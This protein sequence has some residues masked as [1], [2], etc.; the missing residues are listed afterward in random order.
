MLARTLK[1]TTGLAARRWL[2]AGGLELQTLETSLRPILAELERKGLFASAH[3]NESDGAPVA[4]FAYSLPRSWAAPPALAATPRAA[5]MNDTPY[6]DRS[7]NKPV[8]VA[9]VP[10]E[11]D[12]DDAPHPDAFFTVSESLDV[13][14]VAESWVGEA[15]DDP[16]HGCSEE[17][18]RAMRKAV[19]LLNEAS[20]DYG[21]CFEFARPCRAS[22]DE[23]TYTVG[24]GCVC[25]N[26]ALVGWRQDNVV[27][28]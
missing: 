3:G 18:A 16:D 26:G 4:V 27:W 23:G 6:W 8:W 5:L 25:A 10:G 24:V 13:A 22:G 2:S 1:R 15:D 20:G 11:L 17:D 21:A 7:S 14:E 19:E 9:G 12:P 28:T